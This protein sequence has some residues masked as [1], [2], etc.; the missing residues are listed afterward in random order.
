MGDPQEHDSTSVEKQLGRALG[1]I[2]ARH[3]GGEPSAVEVTF[4]GNVVRSKIEGAEEHS[5]ESSAYTN[6]A[7]RAVGDATGRRVAAFIPK[8]DR[9]AKLTT[10]A[11]ILEH[12]K[13]VH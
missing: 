10:Q 6:A 3:S 8:Y 5:P 1:G 2:W 11:Y 12:A 7:I 9:N 4:D 13:V